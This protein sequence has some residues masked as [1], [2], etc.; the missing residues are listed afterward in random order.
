MR[1]EI[2]IEMNEGI[3][4]VIAVL[5][6]VG[7][8][9]EFTPFFKINPVSYIL[10]KLGTAMNKDIAEQ[11]TKLAHQMTEHEID[12]LRWNILNFANSCRNGRKHSKDEFEHVI[13][14]HSKYLKILENHGMQNGQVE[15]DYKF[16]ERVYHKCMDENDFL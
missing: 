16:I 5:T 8:V 1:G 3:Q 7:I 12:E 11:V 15:T 9:V 4:S 2:V 6:S 14:D 13:S 10:K